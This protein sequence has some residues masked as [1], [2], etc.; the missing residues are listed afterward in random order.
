MLWTHSQTQRKIEPVTQVP[1][2]APAP[3]TGAPQPKLAG[4][5]PATEPD[6]FAARLAAAPGS[7]DTIRLMRD[8]ASVRSFTGEKIP[9]EVLHEILE[10][11][12]A[13]STWRN[14]QSYSIIVTE[15]LAIREKVQE[16]VHQPWITKSAVFLLFVGDLNR[17]ASAVALHGGEFQP[18]GVEPVLVSAV[19]AA[20]AA[21]NIMLAAESLGYGGVFIGVVRS[22]SPALAELFGLTGY[23][24]PITGMCLGR[25]KRKNPAKQRL[26][27]DSMVFTDRYQQPSADIV[28]AYDA[29]DKTNAGATADQDWSDRLVD[30]WGQPTQ[31]ISTQFL[32]DRHII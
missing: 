17:A 9:P 31:Q 27:F 32:R 30:Q 21:Q 29:V 8:H 2:P 24:Y 3:Y 12:R 26:P 22:N 18:S 23:T 14:Q 4:L 28:P 13:A 5:A 10:A 7:T 1:T 11:G 25:P 20:L 6:G 19:D 15:D 16:L